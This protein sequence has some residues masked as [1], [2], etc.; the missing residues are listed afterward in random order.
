M[1]KC[2]KNIT[3]PFEKVIFL[4]SQSMKIILKGVGRGAGKG[5]TETYEI[6]LSDKG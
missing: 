4:E 2:G 5:Y 6:A 1:T 3:I